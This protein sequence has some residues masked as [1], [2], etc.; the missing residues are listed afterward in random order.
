MKTGGLRSSGTSGRGTAA[1]ALIVLWPYT[2]GLG[3]GAGLA[4]GA[5][6]TCLHIAAQTLNTAVKDAASAQPVIGEQKARMN[7]GML[8]PLTR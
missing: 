4:Y 2:A 6:M 3:R 7:A 5:T 8:K 1:I